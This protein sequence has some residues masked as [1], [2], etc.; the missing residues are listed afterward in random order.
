MLRVGERRL[1]SWGK[2]PGGEQAVLM[3]PWVKGRHEGKFERVD[4]EARVGRQAVRVPA[5][6]ISI[7][8]KK[9][10]S[11]RTF[12]F[13]YWAGNYDD[14]DDDSVVMKDVAKKAFNARVEKKLV[15]SSA[16]SEERPE[17]RQLSVSGDAASVVAAAV[18]K[19][20]GPPPGSPVFGG[21]A[22]RGALSKSSP[23]RGLAE[24]SRDDGKGS[25]KR[26]VSFN[27]GPANDRGGPGESSGGSLYGSPRGARGAPG[28][29]ETVIRRR[30]ADPGREATAGAAGKAGPA[31]PREGPPASERPPGPEEPLIRSVYPT[32][33]PVMPPE[34]QVAPCC[35]SGSHAGEE[36]RSSEGTRAGRKWCSW[37]T[38]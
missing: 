18:S 37:T 30:G 23:G 28:T 35:P 7:G 1:S 16:S 25:R 26:M 32:L 24:E 13:K 31:A 34:R 38:A 6:F 22:I 2:L 29:P 10:P 4:V 20:A 11:F 21:P 5:R 27:S 14:F 33:D 15:E 12:A 8:S 19:T 9:L 36:L 17:P 3:C